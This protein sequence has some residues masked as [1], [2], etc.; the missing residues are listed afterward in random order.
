[1]HR[2]VTKVDVQKTR[3][4][5]AQ[6]TQQLVQFCVGH[7]PRLIAQ[8]SKPKPPND[9]RSQLGNDVKRFKRIASRVFAFLR[10][11]QR[12]ASFKTREFPN[13]MP[14]SLFEKP[15]AITNDNRA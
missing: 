4:R 9:M 6:D 10:K 2:D 1:M 12:S 15:G 13:N 11:Q 5:F 3:A 14:Q 8:L 7:L